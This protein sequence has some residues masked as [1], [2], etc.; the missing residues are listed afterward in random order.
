MKRI[1]YTIVQILVAVNLVFMPAPAFAQGACANLDESFQKYGVKEFPNLPKYCAIGPLVQK[2]F[3]VALTL[4][5]SFAIIMIM[6]GG[7]YYMTARGNE[8]QAAKGRKTALYALA[9]LAVVL[10][11]V[12]IV[13]VV[14]NAIL[15]GRL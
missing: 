7:Y 12:T 13:N 1:F 5:A 15:Y 9:G 14:I 11:S 4:V 10:L 3:N 6:I 8:T 2:I